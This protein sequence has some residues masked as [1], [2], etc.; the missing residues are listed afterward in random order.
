[1]LGKL[2]R[3]S[4]AEGQ[5]EPVFSQ[6]VWGGGQNSDL[7]ASKIGTNELAHLTNAVDYEKYIEGH[8]G[9]IRLA[10]TSLPGSG[11]VHSYGFH[12]TAK[13][14]LLHRGTGLW[15]ADAAIASWT[16]V[17]SISSPGLTFVPTISGD[18]GANFA[19]MRIRG[20][21]ASNTNAGILYWNF[22]NAAGTRT[23]SVYKDAAKTQLVAQG[24]TTGSLD[25]FASQRNES[26]LLIESRQ[27]YS[28]DDTDSGNTIDVSLN[29]SISYANLQSSI[30]TYKN[31]FILFIDNSSDASFGPI[32]YVD[33]TTN[34]FFNLGGVRGFGYPYWRIP[35]SGAQGSATPYGRR[36][37]CTF[38]RISGASTANRVTGTLLFES[39]ANDLRSTTSA[40]PSIDYGE[41][42]TANPI[43]DANPATVSFA[44]ATSPQLIQIGAS[45]HYT[46]ISLY[47]TLDIG[48]AGVDPVSGLGNNRELYVWVDDIDITLSSYS[49]TTTDDKLR[50]RLGRFMLPSRF[51]KSLPGGEC[52]CIVNDFLFNAQ[53]GQPKM[54]YQQLLKPEL[55]GFYRPDAQYMTFED[56]VQLLAESEEQVAVICSRQTVKVNPKITKNI[57]AIS[58]VFTINSRF[59]ASKTIGVTD[60]GSIQTLETGGF[61]ARCTDGSVRLWNG[62]AWGDDLGEDRVRDTLLN[63][64]DGSSSAYIKKAYYL[65]YRTG[66]GD[67]YNTRCLR[68]GLGGD[69]GF[70]WS[71]ISRSTWIFPHLRC[72][73]V[74]V[75]DSTN[76]ARLMVLDYT[77]GNVFWIE[78]F[79]NAG[80]SFTKAWRDR[81]NV[82]GG[83]DIAATIRLREF[84]GTREN[85]TL[86]HGESHGYFRPSIPADGYLSGFQVGLAIYVDGASTAAASQSNSPR[87]G[88]IQLSKV[89]QG[90]RLQPEITTNTS[91][92]QLVGYDSD[93]VEQDKATIGAQF[94]ET[95][96]AGYQLA[97]ASSLRHLLCRP[98]PRLNR[99]T[100]TNYALA[101][102]APT[103][104]TGPDGKT[105]ALSFPSGASYTQVDTTSYAD[106][107]VGFFCK[108]V[109]LNSRIFLIDG[110]ND[111]YV[112]FTS[113]TVMDV[114]GAGNITV[115]TIASG[116]HGFWIVRT[117]ST[118]SVYQAG[119]LVG[120]VTVAT[121]RG[122]TQFQWNPDGAAMILDVLMVR[123]DDISAGA[124]AYHYDDVVNNT[125]KRLLPLA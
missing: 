92:F 31:D 81:E 12:P 98:M 120:T 70:G 87:D 5:N 14:W 26:G 123:N 8:G 91:K 105:Y 40:T 121:A 80:S 59:P 25:I 65:W 122:G 22:S 118:V 78:T 114:N 10:S 43:S 58:S 44:V 63:M 13:R 21:N 56:G 84:T 60:W 89:A 108:T 83:T 68:L 11:T 90:R 41:H 9:S 34:K 119:A 79:T 46:H 52:G 96:E 100:G 35:D 115:A 66:T 47:A 77:T 116:W 111:F 50:S 67:A 36:Y 64:I 55:M 48:A 99:A 20:Q 45:D 101:G 110:A 112:Q 76:L 39:A 33:L 62:D 113:N 73:G 38:S 6:D 82:S 19:T 86:A 103:A 2:R 85:R 102:T 15:T 32:A 95:D 71:V 27:A 57:D 4:R 93:I 54:H 104:V 42:W 124:I 23:L 88:D 109:A 49:D 72:G 30:R 3:K 51:W 53:R 69:A 61:I 16:S 117:G 94:A 125:G 75:L 24:T 37:I 107:A 28:G 18:T 29:L 1:M 17:T 7:P 74:V 97:L 106:F